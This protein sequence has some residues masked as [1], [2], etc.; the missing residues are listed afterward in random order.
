M[1]ADASRRWRQRNPDAVKKA[2]ALY[3]QRHKEKLKERRAEAN[4]ARSR[5]YRLAAVEALGGICVRCG[6]SDERALQIDHVDGGGG[7]ERAQ[8]KSRSVFYRKVVEDQKG[9][10]LL[11][12]NCN[13]IK[14]HENQEYRWRY[15]STED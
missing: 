12:A 5:A 6:F 3:Y 9:Y 1:S 14:R 15:T 7:M 13:W 2:K 11:C 4:L 10:Q 8:I